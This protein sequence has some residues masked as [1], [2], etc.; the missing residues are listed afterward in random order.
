VQ[1]RILDA[2]VEVGSEV[3]RAVQCRADLE[4]DALR[5]RVLATLTEKRSHYDSNYDNFKNKLY[6]EVR[7]EAF[8]EDIGQNSWLTAAELDGFLRRLALA[9]GNSLLDV[10]CGAGGPALRIAA[11][12]GCSVVG[13]D[14][15]AQAVATANELAAERGLARVAE[16]R[17]VDASQR[18]PFPDG[19]FDAITCID[20]INHFSD[21]PRVLLEW[22]RVLKKTG[23]ILFT[24]P[25]V[26]TG[27]L[28]NAEISIR[29]SAGFYLLVPEGYDE[30][31]LR[32]GG[33]QLVAT[34]NITRNMA[35][36]A[37]RRRAAREEH[38]AG[39]R[40][41]EGD[42]AYEAQQEYLGVA[43]RIAS[44]GRLSRF[45]FVAEKMV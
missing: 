25:I 33:L 23:R 20:A 38:E 19:S 5:Q 18:L 36:I 10:G 37:E 40:K 8:G 14:A 1:S 15:H 41:V 30:R 16:F 28:T 24:D 9:S 21:R 44:E 39:L 31:C 3:I 32:E 35:E 26:M 22:R 27:P 4:F 29:T 45:L 6:E 34:E 12:T 42:R 17:P 43:A 13:I 2:R 11:L 7:R